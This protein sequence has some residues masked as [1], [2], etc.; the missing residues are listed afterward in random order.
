LS[1]AT[2]RALRES[3]VC[4]MVGMRREREEGGGEGRDGRKW[5]EVSGGAAHFE[6]FCEGVGLVEAR[7]LI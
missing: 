5:R 4:D 7:I 3:D 6:P 2:V 1:L